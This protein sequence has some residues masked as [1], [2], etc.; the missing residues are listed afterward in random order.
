VLPMVP[1]HTTH[2][3]IHTMYIH[4]THTTHI[5][6]HTTHTYSTHTHPHHIH[7]QHTHNTHMTHIHITHTQH[8]HIAYVHIHSTHIYTTHTHHIHTQHTYNINTHHTYIHHTE[9][10]TPHIHTTHTHFTPYTH[11]RY[12]HPTSLQVLAKGRAVLREKT[13]LFLLWLRS[14]RKEQPFSLSLTLRAPDTSELSVRLLL[15]SP[16]QHNLGSLSLRMDCESILI[17]KR[18]CGAA[19]PHHGTG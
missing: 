13:E 16:G 18:V 17:S 11:H 2:T 3:H 5:H 14:Q 1:I 8:K 9:R 15:F 10:H 19:A 6:N 12:T 4:S 7:T